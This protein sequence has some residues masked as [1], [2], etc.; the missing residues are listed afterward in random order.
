[1]YDQVTFLP[2]QRRYNIDGLKARVISVHLLLSYNLCYSF[3][4]L[5][6]AKYQKITTNLQTQRNALNETLS[7]HEFVP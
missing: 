3:Y 5:I 6:Y 2:T 4:R 1:M 7:L